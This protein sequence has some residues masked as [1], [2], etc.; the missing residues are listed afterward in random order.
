M[1]ETLLTALVAALL[2]GG[3]LGAVLTFFGKRTSDRNQREK[4]HQAGILATEQQKLANTLA[5]EQ[6]NQ[7]NMHDLITTLNQQ[8]TA[9]RL[10]Q[11]EDR[12][13]FRS[14]ITALIETNNKLEMQIEQLREQNWTF[15][16]ALEDYKR[17]SSMTCPFRAARVL[18]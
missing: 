3:G 2:G 8:V 7:K 14:E 15:K 1:S 18:P 16:A 5:V 12:G 10:Q 9:L 6:Q 13:M 17:C 4:D 11:S